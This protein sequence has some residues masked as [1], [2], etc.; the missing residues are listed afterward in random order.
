MNVLLLPAPLAVDATVSSTARGVPAIQLAEYGVELGSLAV[1]SRV[2]SAQHA[3]LVYAFEY[4]SNFSINQCGA[5]PLP[6]SIS[7]APTPQ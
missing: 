4:W 2:C 1:S 3:R 5:M 7:A 6:L